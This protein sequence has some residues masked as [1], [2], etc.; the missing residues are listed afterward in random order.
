[1]RRLLLVIPLVAGLVLVGVNLFRAVPQSGLGEPAPRF[2]LP[3]VSRP[4]RR[5]GPGSFSGR[6]VVVNFW[7]SWCEPCREEAPELRRVSQSHPE[8]AFLGVSILDGRREAQ[9]YLKEFGITY[10]SVRDASGRTSKRFG[11]T[12]VP[13]TAF[14]DSRG[15]L[16]GSY[17]GAFTEGQLDRL[18]TDLK[19]LA[20]GGLL[21][22]SGSGRSRPVP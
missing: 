11:V 4:D 20:P 3:D 18:V 19:T 21:E 14:L 6:P 5:L 15:R 7:A 9:E 22:I 16:V 1:M 2:S 17:A 8:V 10:P 12:G 13:E